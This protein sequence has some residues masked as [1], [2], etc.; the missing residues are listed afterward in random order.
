[1]SCGVGCRHSLDLGLLWL[2]C[3]QAA[4]AP[5]QPLAWE[6]PYAWGLQDRGEEGKEEE[7]RKEIR[8][9]YKEQ[10]SGYH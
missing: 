3:R 1:M 8:L 7:K 9:R 5:I 2:F 4:V 10:T 6:F